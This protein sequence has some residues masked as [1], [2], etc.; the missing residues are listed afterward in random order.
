MNGRRKAQHE[1]AITR[2]KKQNTYILPYILIY[3]YLRRPL[4][5]L[6][7]GWE[8]EAKAELIDLGRSVNELSF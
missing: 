8:G 3:S 1:H 2:Y 7:G 6:S 5:H 4:R